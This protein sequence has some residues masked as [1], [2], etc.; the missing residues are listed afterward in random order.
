MAQ[1]ASSGRLT[2][3]FGFEPGT[4]LAEKY[5]VLALLGSGWEGEVY[6]VCE[7]RTDIERA[8]I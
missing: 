4:I 5:E 6:R 2:V 1:R 3:P 7:L 8:A